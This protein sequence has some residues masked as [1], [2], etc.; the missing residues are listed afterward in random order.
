MT[1]WSWHVPVLRKN[2][3]GESN[4]WDDGL[5]ATDCALAASGDNPAALIERAELSVRSGRVAPNNQLG[6]QLRAQLD[7]L[8][9][10][11]GKPL[12]D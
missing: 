5:A 8:V 6:S 12:A 3:R 10:E 9:A 2:S 11:G 4:A 1:L 7:K